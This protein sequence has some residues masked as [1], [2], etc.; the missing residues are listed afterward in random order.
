M[1]EALYIWGN[2]FRG[3][4]LMDDVRPRTANYSAARDNSQTVQL[5]GVAGTGTIA[6]FFGL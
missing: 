1:D 3:S 6:E 4:A 2:D 5:E